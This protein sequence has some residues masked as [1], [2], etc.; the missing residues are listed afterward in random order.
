MPKGKGRM[1]EPKASHGMISNEY[2]KIKFAYGKLVLSESY[3]FRVAY[4]SSI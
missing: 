4:K 1:R 3:G 2:D